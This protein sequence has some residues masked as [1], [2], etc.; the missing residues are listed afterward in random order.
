MA[1]VK[2]TL[3][4][5]ALIKQL[6]ENPA[7]AQELMLYGRLPLHLQDAFVDLTG[8]VSDDSCGCEG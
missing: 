1:S 6:R 7:E 3:L 4:L 5:A 8:V 2:T